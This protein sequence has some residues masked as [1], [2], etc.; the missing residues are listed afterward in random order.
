MQAATSLGALRYRES[1]TLACDATLRVRHNTGRDWELHKQGGY[2]SD[3]RL[4]S[5]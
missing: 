1:G 4:V 5:Q 3:G 2:A